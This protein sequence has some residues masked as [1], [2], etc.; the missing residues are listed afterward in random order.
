MQSIKLRSHVGQ[1]GILNLRVPV[2]VTETDVEVIVVVQDLAPATSLSTPESLKWP[3][4][5]FE[6]TFGCLKDDPI[7]RGEQGEYES[8][9][10]LQ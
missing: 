10:E 1:D 4:G 3:A 8:R 6:Q 9:D 7:V 5:F 2:E